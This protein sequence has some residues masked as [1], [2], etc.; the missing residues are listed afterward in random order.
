MNPRFAIAACALAAAACKTSN[1]VAIGSASAAAVPASASASAPAW[2]GVPR[3]PAEVLKVIN[4]SGREPYSGLTATL[5][6]RVTIKGDPAP[7]SP[8]TFPAE[9]CP[10]AAP[11]YGK[12]FRVGQD[13][14][15]ADAVVMVAGYDA[16]V[17]PEKPAVQ[18]K[19][20]GCAFDTRTVAMTFG[21]R[22]EIVND[23]ASGSYTPYL[24]GSEYRAVLLSMPG[25]D[26]VPLYPNKPA[27]N[28]VLRDF[29][30]RNFMAADVLVLKFATLDVT[31]LDGRYEIGRIPVGKV[32]VDVY[33]PA[34]DKHVIKEI[35]LASGD[36]TL[37][38]E[39]TY[40]AASDKV[41]PRRPDPWVRGTDPNRE[42]AT[43]GKFG[44]PPKRAPQDVPKDV[45][46]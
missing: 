18:V 26:P 28:Y 7:A 44:A 38:L 31:G 9:G 23:D 6:G 11:T 29:Q 22:L 5:K 2:L 14:A 30:A 43:D 24:D 4:K 41:V 27:I 13:S 36:N 40:D 21:Q 8:D 17:P 19:V 15:L 16:F 32:S 25:G 42:A 1:D 46:R 45:P 12:A 37:D 20:A 34:L 39:M 3:P 10:L 35:E 33:L